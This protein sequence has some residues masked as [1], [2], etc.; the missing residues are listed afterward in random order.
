MIEGVSNMP[1]N[2]QTIQRLEKVLEQGPMNPHEIMYAYKQRW[3][4]HQPTMSRLGNLLSRHPQF[5]STGMD[6]IEGPIGAD[7]VKIWALNQTV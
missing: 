2:I 3:P 1:K 5:I 7:K 4:K 6:K